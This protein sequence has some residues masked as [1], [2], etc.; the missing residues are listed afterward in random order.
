MNPSELQC[1]REGDASAHCNG[2][3][4]MPNGAGSPTYEAQFQR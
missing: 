2:R 4:L 3:N 1:R